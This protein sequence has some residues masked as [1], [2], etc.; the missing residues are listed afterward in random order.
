LKTTRNA[1]WLIACRLSGDALNVLLFVLV[2]RQFGPA[3][4]GAYSYGF[5]VSSFVFVIGCLGIEEYG[6]RQYARMDSSR[7][8]AFLAE[9]LGTQAVLVAFAVAAL[10]AYLLLTAPSRATVMMVIGLSCYQ[11]AAAVAGTLFIPAMAQQ[12]MEWPALAQFGSRAVAFAGAGIAISFA[13]SSLALALLGFPLAAVIWLVVAVRS[14]RRYA[15]P[16]SIEISAAGLRGIVGVLWSFALIELFAQLLTRVG[17]ITLSLRMGDAPAGLF[18]TGLRLIEVALVPLNFLGVAAYPRLSQL[19][20]TDVPAFRRSA[21]DLMWLMLLAGS[22]LAWGLW[23]VAPTLLVPVLGARFAGTEPVIQTMAVFALVQ[24]IEIGLG[25]I[26]LCADL[27][28][29]RAAFIVGGAILSVALNLALV[30]RFGV[31]GAIYA[32]AIAFASIDI[33]A[34]AALRRP[35]TSAVLLP[36]LLTFGTSLA[37]GAGIAAV[38]AWQ[39]FG[40]SWQASSSAAAFILVGAAGYRYGRRRAARTLR[41]V[42]FD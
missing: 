13:H 8:P 21:T 11:I 37:L 32:G 22:G 23:F 42:P 26:L 5:A 20:T 1:A 40:S 18:A 31:D 24:A 36:V 6:L 7:R 12:R 4:V 30:P 38:L 34:V 35:L 27:Q 15:G 41:L 19:F 29:S 3:G 33:L 2:S 39:G 9:L 10:I 25:R 17:M 14:A 28:I 16:I